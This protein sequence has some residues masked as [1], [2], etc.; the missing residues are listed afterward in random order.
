[1]EKVRPMDR[2][3]PAPPREEKDMDSDELLHHLTRFGRR[4][5]TIADQIHETREQA[6]HALDRVYL[7]CDEVEQLRRELAAAIEAER[8]LARPRAPAEAV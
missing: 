7:L 3:P 4:L 2:E 5:T 1:M 6:Q 8:Y